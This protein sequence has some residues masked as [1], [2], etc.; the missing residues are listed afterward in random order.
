MTHRLE[1]SDLIDLPS[2]S[3]RLWRVQMLRSF[4]NTA[5]KLARDAH[6]RLAMGEDHA[7][8]PALH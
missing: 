8:N 5:R 7:P 2:P 3:R 4:G 6:F 1:H